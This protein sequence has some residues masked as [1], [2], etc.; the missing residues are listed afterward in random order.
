MNKPEKGFYYHYKHDPSK[1]M[2]NYAYEVLNIAHHTEMHD[3]G[4]DG[5][6]VIYRPIYEAFVYKEGKQWYARPLPMFLEKVVKDG[7]EIERFS[8]V[9]DIETVTKLEAKAKEMYS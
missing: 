8:K 3:T 4:D 9:T 7:K 6:L 5:L 2:Y 1:D